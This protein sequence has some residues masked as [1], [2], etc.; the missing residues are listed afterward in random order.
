MTSHEKWK[1]IPGYEGF[2]EVSDQGRVRSLD[3]IVS[4]GRRIK[5]QFLS[6]SRVRGGHLRVDLRKNGKREYIF[7]HRLVLLAFVGPCPTGMEA[8]HWNDVPDDNRLENLR[9]D[10][11]S[12]NS[13][14]ASRNGRHYNANKTH[15]PRGHEYTPENTYVRRTGKRHCRECRRILQR[16]HYRLKSEKLNAVR[17]ERYRARALAN[18]EVDRG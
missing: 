8:C 11:S 1:A 18:V 15:C 16:A 6:P 14:D 12:A 7:V 3:R 9:W 13:R 17:R 2:Y 5:G 4:N 10:T